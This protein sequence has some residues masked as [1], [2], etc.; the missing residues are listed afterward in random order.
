MCY[1]K[2]SGPEP[3]QKP[4]CQDPELQTRY[5]TQKKLMLES[6]ESKP[7]CFCLSLTALSDFLSGLA[8]R[9]SA[10]H[11][12]KQ[13]PIGHSWLGTPLSSILSFSSITGNK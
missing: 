3:R 13:N 9:H 4:R 7:A 11:R 1:N 5:F 6:K 8:A 10:V 2:N 12:D